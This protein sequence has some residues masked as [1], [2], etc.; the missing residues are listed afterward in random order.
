M[1][2]P[3]G[4]KQYIS[5]PRFRRV[6]NYLGSLFSEGKCGSPGKDWKL[7]LQVNNIL[8][9]SCEGLY[10]HSDLGHS[11]CTCSCPHEHKQRL[12][13]ELLASSQTFQ[14]PPRPP[15]TH[16]LTGTFQSSHHTTEGAGANPNSK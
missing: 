11:P 7:A 9:K 5:S 6:I 8:L 16:F 4:K 14:S 12:S 15:P 2:S 10:R 3:Q 1:P 13:K